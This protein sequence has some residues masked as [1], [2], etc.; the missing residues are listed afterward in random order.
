M[1]RLHSFD[2]EVKDY[3]L[4]RPDAFCAIKN[5]WQDAFHFYFIEMDINRS[6]HDFGKKARK[7]NELFSSGAYMN[8]WWVPLS[9]RFPAIIV[10]TTGRV[11]TIKE[12]IERENVNN[13][14][15]RIYSLDT[16][17]EECRH[18][19]GGKTSIRA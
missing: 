13:L 7:Y 4:I 2:R 10:V 17:K 14:E 15:F 11:K 18:D 3:K 6:G 19:G 8:Q 16:I 9:K 5:L 12:K 1:D